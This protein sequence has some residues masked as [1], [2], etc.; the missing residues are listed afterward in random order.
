M[1]A[2][3]LRDHD[4]N[5]WQTWDA[6]ANRYSKD[7]SRQLKAAFALLAKHVADPKARG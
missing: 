1:A 3:W 7:P 4:V 5:F 2:E 6:M